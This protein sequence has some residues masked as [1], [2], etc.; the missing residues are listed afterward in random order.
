M[1]LRRARTPA[2]IL[3][4]LAASNAM[5]QNPPPAPWGPSKTNA[6]RLRWLQYTMAAGRITVSSAYHGTNMTLGPLEIERRRERL[7]IQI[8]PGRDQPALRP[9]HRRRAIADRA[10]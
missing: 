8:N 7:Q 6:A 9:G 4:V 2:A 1:N 5:A 3:L 10:D